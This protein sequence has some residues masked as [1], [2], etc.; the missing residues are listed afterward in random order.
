[1]IWNRK[2]LLKTKMEGCR[3][4]K[5][6]NSALKK[7][8]GLD[9]ENATVWDPNRRWNHG[10]PRRSLG[11]VSGPAVCS[12]SGAKCS[13]YSTVWNQ[14]HY[15]VPSGT[16]ICSNTRV[17]NRAT[18]VVT[19]V[20]TKWKCRHGVWHNYGTYNSTGQC[21]WWKTAS[22]KKSNVTWWKTIPFWVFAAGA[23]ICFTLLLVVY[24]VHSIPKLPRVPRVRRKA[25][26]IGN[27]SYP[28]LDTSLVGACEDARRMKTA[29]QNAGF[30]VMLCIDVEQAREI[31]N[32]FQKS[33]V[34]EYHA[35][36]KGINKNEDVV[37]YFAGHGL[38]FLDS[39]WIVAGLA[40]LSSPGDIIHQCVE[41]NYLR[42]F[43]ARR[44]PRMTVFVI[45]CC[46]TQLAAQL[47]FNFDGNAKILDT[48]K[49]SMVKVEDLNSTLA[50]LDVY[51][52]H[53]A[54]EATHAMESS[55][56]GDFTT[57][58]LKHMAERSLTLDGLSQ[59]I[60]SDM[61]TAE[62]LRRNEAANCSNEPASR[63]DLRVGYSV[64]VIE[65]FLSDN[66]GL[67]EQVTLTI[68]MCGK[69]VQIDQEGD[70]YVVFDDHGR[71]LR[72][73]RVL[74]NTQSLHAYRQRATE[75]WIYKEKFRNLQRIDGVQIAPAEDYLTHEYRGWCFYDS[76]M[77]CGLMPIYVEDVLRCI[78]YF[79][80]AA[81][82][83]Y[84]PQGMTNR[85]AGDTLLDD[86]Y[87]LMN[88]IS[89]AEERK[90]TKVAR[91]NLV[92]LELDTQCNGHPVLVDNV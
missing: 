61:K 21:L 68:G 22:V 91:P 62:E 25:L 27:G 30:D 16:T 44:A 57:S 79:D 47:G 43:L 55:S 37:F 53:G 67:E 51:I 5:P 52:F 31:V 60:R 87:V 4:V 83:G 24:C 15:L 89:Q 75:F 19:R 78:F 77:F 49:E 17:M 23:G 42:M 88:D 81:A 73:D 45:D 86:E 35:W 46:D 72:R 38:R 1:M 6:V 76:V 64:E 50:A 63:P 85:N 14:K 92:L 40:D 90:V 28:N 36:C 48:L 54:A 13:T 74:H 58:F 29:L 39:Q 12:T 20:V 26:C 32:N 9:C 3:R 33:I 71:G 66:S 2:C 34:H 7:S 80:Y 69:V 10:G 82:S 56:G 70:A 59:K 11:Y 65:E 41:L 8:T 84:L 18:K